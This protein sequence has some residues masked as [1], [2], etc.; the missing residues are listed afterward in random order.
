LVRGEL[1]FTTHTPVPAGHDE[2][3]WDLASYHLAPFAAE[4]GVDFQQL[5]Q[6]ATGPDGDRWSQTV[7]AL[8]LAGKAN[9]V[10]RLH[11]HVSRRMWASL[12][13]DRPVDEVPIGHVTNGVH[14]GLW[15]GPE[16]A[17]LFDARLGPAWRASDGAEAWQRVRDIEPAVLW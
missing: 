8:A 12:W 1:V 16:L 17:A 13:P 11:G 2:F 3:G 6:L 15:V 4:L 5:W 14:P 9:G 10:A 7:L